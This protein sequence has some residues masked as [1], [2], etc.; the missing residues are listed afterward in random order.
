MSM[1]HTEH[2]GAEALPFSAADS[3]DECNSGRP[4]PPRN[5]DILNYVTLD[6][7]NSLRRPKSVDRQD[8]SIF[9]RMPFDV[10]LQVLGHLHPLDLIHVSRTSRDF[11]ELLH[12]P[13]AECIWR[14]AFGGDTGLPAPP[15]SISSARIWARLIY[16]PN[17]CDDCGMPHCL[18]DYTLWRRLCTSCLYKLDEQLP[19]YAYDHDIYELIPRTF[20]QARDRTMGKGYFPRFDPAEGKATLDIYE[21]LQAENE[22]PALVEFKKSRRAIVADI[23]SAASN[24]ASWAS[25]LLEK[26]ESREEDR[27][28][29]LTW[30]RQRLR[31]EGWADAEI[32]EA[33]GSYTAHVPHLRMI[34]ALSHKLWRRLRPYLVC[35]LPRA[36]AL[37][38][39]IHLQRLHSQRFTVIEQTLFSAL[40]APVPGFVNVFHP[41]PGKIFELPSLRSLTRDPSDDELAPDDPRLGGVLSDARSFLN[42]WVTTQYE[43]LAALL[44]TTVADR[45]PVQYD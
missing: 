2:P 1:I 36:R 34:R 8:L 18:P 25:D 26:M 42:S 32:Q 38:R 5:F 10:I 9:P 44:P 43:Y 11:R 6:T 28:K 37:L 24:C 15:T 4:F 13:T 16:G 17:I 40:G 7:W 27:R 22:E 23:N 31:R 41:F 21:R 39:R 45:G 14:D 30:I 20:R 19:G 33:S 12:S 3:F 29:I 35:H